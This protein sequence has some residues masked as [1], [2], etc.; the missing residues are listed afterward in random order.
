MDRGI[1]VDLAGRV[2]EISNDIEGDFNV[3]NVGIVEADRGHQDEESDTEVVLGL[4][5]R[6]FGIRQLD[7]RLKHVESGDCSRIV[8]ALLISDLCLVERNLLFVGDH[9]CA[10]ENDLVELLDDRCD[11]GINRLAQL[12]V[13][14]LFGELGSRRE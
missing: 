9:E 4:N 7:L 5:Q 3:L 12:E 11:R 6:W 1:A 10:V 13:G 8:A 14:D 2:I